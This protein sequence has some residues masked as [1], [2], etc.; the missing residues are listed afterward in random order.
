[1]STRQWASLSDARDRLVEL[2]PWLVLV[3]DHIASALLGGGVTLQAKLPN[4]PMTPVR[5]APG[6]ELRDINVDKNTLSRRVTGPR[7]HGC[8]ET[9]RHV[10]ADRSELRG[11]F[12]EKGLIDDNADYSAIRIKQPPGPK[13]KKAAFKKWWEAG[14]HSEGLLHEQIA[15]K[16]KVVP[17]TVSRWFNGK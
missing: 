3:N 7:G 11:Y 16:F 12:V 4:G 14:G 1:M 10:E 8:W 9:M 13:G 15:A 2:N 6:D 5:L 17:R